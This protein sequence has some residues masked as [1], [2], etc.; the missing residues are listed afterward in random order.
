MAGA[1]ASLSVGMASSSARRHDGWPRDCSCAQSSGVHG[2]NCC[3]KLKAARLAVA[4]CLCESTSRRCAAVMSH[5]SGLSGM[6]SVGHCRRAAR[7]APHSASS[8]VGKSIR[9]AGPFAGSERSA[10]SAARSSSCRL[11]D[12]D[13]DFSTQ[14]FLWHRLPTGTD[15]Y[16]SVAI[17]NAAQAD[18]A[19]V[20]LRGG[21]AL[22][23]K[24][25]GDP[26]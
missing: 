19:A 23:S 17:K 6:P 9:E 24:P 12:S 13:F 5:A 11:A 10:Q 22:L 2:L 8:R 20:E 18:A 4:C 1:L 7:N 16:D 14:R 25:F 3:L 21:S 15:P 26:M